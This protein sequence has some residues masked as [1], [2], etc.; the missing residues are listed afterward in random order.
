MIHVPSGQA[1]LAWT[2][3]RPLEAPRPS[4]A[5]TG[6]GHKLRGNH[7]L[8]K[9]FASVVSPHDRHSI[10][11]GTR[12]VCAHMSCLQSAPRSK[13]P[14]RP[15]SRNA[16][17]SA[18][19]KPK[20]GPSGSF[21]SR[22]KIISPSKATSTQL[23]P[24]LAGLRRQTSSDLSRRP[25]NTPLDR[26]RT[27]M[28]DCAKRGRSDLLGRQSWTVAQTIDQSLHSG[29]AVQ[30]AGAETDLTGPACTSCPGSRERQVTRSRLV[31]I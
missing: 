25:T 1:R 9:T 13:T 30:Q 28:A 22:T 26:Q 4:A 3:A 21:E 19:Q 11:A 7:W 20:Q 15:A 12:G 2:P 8:T 27:Q 14:R 18:S 29:V 31:R 6:G 5:R 17:H 24:P 16:D 23:L 10:Y